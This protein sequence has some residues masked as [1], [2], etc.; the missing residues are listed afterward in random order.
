MN[1]I[2]R[3]IKILTGG[4]YAPCVGTPLEAVTSE[5][6]EVRHKGKFLVQYGT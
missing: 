5:V 6:I 2:Y 3:K 4:A 1:F